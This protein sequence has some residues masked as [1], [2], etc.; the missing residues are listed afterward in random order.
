MS[1]PRQLD[2]SETKTRL[3]PPVLADAWVTAPH[4]VVVADR[5]GRV[6][7]ANEA[8]RLLLPAALDGTAL[9]EAVP[10]WLADAHARLAAAD[11]P[12]VGADS[13]PTGADIPPAEAQARREPDV[14]RGEIGESSFEARPA[15]LDDG[16]WAWWLAE[17]TYRRRAED[18]LRAERRRTALLADASQQLLASLN[19]ERC[20]EVTAAMAAGHLCDAAIVIA[21]GRGNV[22]PVTHTGPA[23]EATHAT[24]EVDLTEVPGLGEAMQGFPPVPSRWIDPATLPDW[25][26]PA[27]F[28]GPVCSVV[29]TPLPGHGVPAGALILLRSTERSAFSEAEEVFAR[30]FA[31]RAGAAVSAAQL[32]AEQSAISRTLMRDL[33]PPEL[34]PVHGVEFAGG[35]VA[36]GAGEHVGGDFYDVHAGRTPEDETLAVLGDVCGKG[37]EAAA[38]TGK[39]RNTVQALRPMGHD[40]QQLLTLLNESL[41]QAGHTRFATLAL[42]SVTRR[43]SIVDL[44]L[45]SAGHPPPLIAR[46]DGTVDEAETRGTLI[47]ALP[48]VTSSTAHVRLKPGEV[49]LMF[50]DGIV[51]AKGGPLGTEMFGEERLSWAL[52]ECFG[53]VAEAVVERVQMLATQ[54]VGRGPHDDMAVV[55]IAAPRHQHLS[56]VDGHTRGRYTG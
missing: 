40:H 1:A 15:R 12:P 17:D 47:G 21:P 51:E 10:E 41:L 8:G 11:T 30:I 48:Q 22:Y 29:I 13:P 44:R 16:H 31:A 35:Y 26:V 18:D 45:T 5:A 39:I 36:A 54:W 24:L 38:L 43:G 4:P 27:H 14:V 32:Y 52:S 56:A 37:L 49:C 55:A 53:M 23:G 3:A 19:V 46:A 2:P 33:L 7:A 34:R 50:S 42:A 9:R 25:A 6:A 28:T 20:M